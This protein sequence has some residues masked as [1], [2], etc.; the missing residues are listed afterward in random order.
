MEVGIVIEDVYWL[1]V[2][3]LVDHIAG[4]VRRLASNTLVKL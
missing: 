4:L 1:T 2:V 3:S